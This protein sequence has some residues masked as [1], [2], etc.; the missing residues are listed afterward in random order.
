MMNN[1]NVYVIY[2]I[3]TGVITG[4]Y[5]TEEECVSVYNYIEREVPESV[6]K[7]DWCGINL[8]YILNELILKRGE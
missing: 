4:T 5:L 7:L 8:Q 1:I 3:E 2:D 6:N